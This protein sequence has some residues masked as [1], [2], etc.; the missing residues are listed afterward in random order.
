MSAAA[1]QQTRVVRRNRLVL[2]RMKWIFLHFAKSDNETI[3]QNV[4]ESQYVAI[5]G[6]ELSIEIVGFWTDSRGGYGD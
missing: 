1:V 6:L 3:Y 5:P 2:R 4:R